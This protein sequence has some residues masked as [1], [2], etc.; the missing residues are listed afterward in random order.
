MS[1]AAMNWPKIAT[2]TPPMSAVTMEV[3]TARCTVSR[4]PRPMALAMTTFAPSAMPM[5]RFKSRPMT[6]LFAPTAATAAV[7]ISPVK[8]PTTAM[9]AA[10][11]SC[12]RMPVAATGRA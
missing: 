4:S 5:N 10:L 12:P 3:C 11:N 9:S 8:L 1:P 2:I 7:R 6:G